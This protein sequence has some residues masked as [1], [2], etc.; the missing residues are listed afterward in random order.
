[1]R[2]TVFLSG[3]RPGITRAELR[4]GEWHVGR[5]LPDADVRCFAADPHHRGRVFAGTQG[6]GLLRSDDAGRTWQAAGLD[7]QI[8]KSIAISP[9]EPG[10]MLAGTKPPLVFASRDGGE[11]WAELEGFR[12]I[13]G[14]DEWWSPAEPPGTAYVLGLAISPEDPAVIVAGIEYG[15]VMRSADRGQTWTAP[16]PNALADCHTLTFHRTDGRYVY[17]GGSGGGVAISRD[18]GQTWQQPRQGL[19]RSYG[20][21]VAADPERPET[22][23]AAISPSPGKAHSDEGIAE[24]YIFRSVDGGAWQRLGGGLPQP[25]DFMPYALLTPEPGEVIAG[26][27]NGDLWRST[28]YGDTWAQLPANLGRVDHALVMLR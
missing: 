27:R 8:V 13:P 14:R 1:M 3:T 12:E 6:D 24:A 2:D 28:D 9:S 4:D 17:E 10:W 18:G 26:L 15:G 20:W 25:L 23:Y 16:L 19:D 22:W 21:A 5:L 7:G 11:T